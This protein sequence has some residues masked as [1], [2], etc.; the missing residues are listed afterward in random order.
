M[1][2]PVL[3]LGLPVYTPSP[4]DPDIS[5]PDDHWFCSKNGGNWTPELWRNRKMGRWLVQR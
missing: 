1:E 4:E 3:D 2:G 5:D